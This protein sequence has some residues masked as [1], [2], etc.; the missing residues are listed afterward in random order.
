MKKIIT[1]PSICEDLLAESGLS[2]VCGVDEA[3]RGPLVGPVVVCAVILPEG[4]IIEGVNDSKKIS[5]KK[6]LILCEEIKKRAISYSY[7]IVDA[8]AIDAINIREATK[9]AMQLAVEGLSVKPKSVLVDGNFTPPLNCPSIYLVKGDLVSHLIAAASILAKVKRDGI[10]E[11]LH[12]QY[13]MYGFNKHKGYGTAA[14]MEAI[15]KH[16]LTPHHRLSFC[17]KW[18]RKF[19]II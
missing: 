12:I 16:N 14:H 3:G 18:L 4:V 2:P 8:A 17:K 19:D 15:N 1:A 9:L 5:E 6:R 7:G 11:E 10:M 13:P